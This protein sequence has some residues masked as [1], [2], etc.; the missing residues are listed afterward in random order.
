LQKH[1]I[2]NYTLLGQRI[3]LIIISPYAKE[4]WIDNYTMSGYTLLAFI[5][6]NWHLPYLNKIV[7]NS[8]VQGLLQAFNFS[9]VPRKP[10][11][12]TPNNW[13]YPIPLQYPIHYG[14]IAT[15]HNNYTGYILLCDRGLINSSVINYIMQFSDVNLY[16]YISSTTSQTSIESSTS[17]YFTNSTSSESTNSTIFLNNTFSSTELN[18]SA[19]TS[20]II[21]SILIIVI[22]FML[23]YYL[24]YIRKRLK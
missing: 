1:G 15:I 9:Q 22:I 18:Q 20:L 13:T 5:D 12:L 6:Y 4:G 7:A 3:P 24:I 23:I 21:S 11:I 19:R 16:E 8:D 17:V 14:Y 10:I 2:Y